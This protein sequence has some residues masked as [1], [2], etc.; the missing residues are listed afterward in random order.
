MAQAWSVPHAGEVRLHL[1]TYLCRVNE[2]PLL[3]VRTGCWCVL[4]SHTQLAQL[5]ALCAAWLVM[6]CAL[7]TAHSYTLHCALCT[8]CYLLCPVCCVYGCLCVWLPADLAVLKVGGVDS[9]Q[10]RPLPRGTSEAGRLRVGQLC[11]AIGNRKSSSTGS[12]L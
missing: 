10:L 7:P 9:Q 8:K 3:F 6:Y 1:A 2:G 11:L 12:T 4:S 5:A